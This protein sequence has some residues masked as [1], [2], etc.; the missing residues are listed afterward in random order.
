[1]RLLLGCVAVALTLAACDTS[2]DL[3]GASDAP[4]PTPTVA[5]TAAT[6]SVSPS[7]DPAERLVRCEN[8]EGFTISYPEA[9]STNPGD[10]VPRCSLFDPEPFDVPMA[11]D[12]RV[13]AVSAYIDPVPF[14]RVSAP[15][16]RRD[17]DRTQLTID[18]LDSVR[19]E[20]AAGPNSLWPE[21][22]PITSYMIDIPQSPDSGDRTLFVDTVGLPGFEYEENQATLDRMARTVGWAGG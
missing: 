16:D 1:M 6:P 3:N 22:T 7:P 20:F 12:E 2:G 17:A 13:A 21:G 8:P 18:G 15:R 10:V 4:S 14:D 9:W 5:D 11:T 19:V